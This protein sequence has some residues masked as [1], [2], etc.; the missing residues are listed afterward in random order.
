MVGI[1][2][3]KKP[4]NIVFLES[5]SSHEDYKNTHEVKVPLETL[6]TYCIYKFCTP[7]LLHVKF[8]PLNRPVEKRTPALSIYDNN[9]IFSYKE[10]VPWQVAACTYP[11]A[12][13]ADVIVTGLC[14]VARHICLFKHSQRAVQ[15]HEHG[16]L[17]FRHSCLQAPNEVSIWTKFC[18]IDLLNAVNEILSTV[19]VKEIPINLVR[20]ENHLKK[21]VRIHNMY[22]IAREMKRE[23]MLRAAQLSDEDDEETSQDAD[24]SND[25]SPIDELPITIPRADFHKNLVHGTGTIQVEIHASLS[26]PVDETGSNTTKAQIHASGSSND[27]QS[28]STTTK[29]EVHAGKSNAAD[30]KSD[31]I[32]TAEIH[33][34]KPGRSDQNGHGATKVEEKPGTSNGHANKVSDTEGASAIQVYEEASTS[35]QGNDGACASSAVNEGASVSYEGI[36]GAVASGSGSMPARL[37]LDDDEELSEPI[38]APSTSSRVPKQRQ[39]KSNNKKEKSRKIE[40]KNLQIIHQFAEGPFFTLADV[41]LLPSYYLIHQAFGDFMFETYLPF[42]AKWFRTVKTVPEVNVCLNLLSKQHVKSLTFADVIVPTPDDVS[43]YKS[44]PKRNNPR[45]RLFTKED[46]IEKALSAITE[47]MELPMTENELEPA[48]NWA[49]IPDGANPTAGH[50]PSDRVTRKTQQLENLA[51]TVLNIAKIRDTIID[52]CCGSGHLGI[53]L[54]YLLPQCTILMLEN[55]E[56]SLDRARARAYQLNLKNVFFYQCNLDFFDGKFDIGIGLHACGIASDL[57]LDKCL[58]AKAKFVISPC[59]Y[60]SLHPTDR[61]AYP[62]SQMFKNVPI[63]QYMCIGHAADQTHKEHPLAVRG[64]R[65]M[66]VIDSDRLRF[67]E[68]SGYKVTLTYLKPLSCTPKNNLLIGVPI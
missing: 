2:F 62:R 3:K 15:E 45:K 1:N 49:S 65:C 55:K 10:D 68:E 50:L 23:E 34:A 33:E 44:D 42:T 35:S 58:K 51:G 59:C 57:V 17:G 31:N 36:E 43:L 47:G 12:M 54:A 30:E 66:T 25:A 67:A 13:C 56:Q 37:L 28:T 32:T 9:L 48:F 60:G 14:A 63:E 16:I 18:E 39:W 7:Q 46:D 6:I 52:F 11:A 5:Y 26:S 64:V 22:K 38:D 8:V 41:V 29:A 53:L 21:P 40:L 27:N 61:I 24:Y 20:Y 4:I 19:H